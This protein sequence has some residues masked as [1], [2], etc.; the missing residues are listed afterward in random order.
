MVGAGGSVQ[1]EHHLWRPARKTS[2]GEIPVILSSRPAR[3]GAPVKGHAAH[4][5]LA[6][7]AAAGGVRRL[8][9]QR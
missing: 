3:P 8:S 4:L 7:A 5:C 9:S 1:S 6:C 2:A